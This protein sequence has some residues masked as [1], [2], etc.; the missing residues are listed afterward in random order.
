MFKFIL[1]RILYGLLTLFLITTATF[2]LIAGAPGDPIA[3]KV[4]QMPEK[5]QAVI[6]TKYGL[7]KPVAVRY[8]IYMKNLITKGDFGESIVYT[9]KS[10]N[11][12]IKTNAPISAKIGIIALAL[13][14]VIGVLLGLISA[15]HRGKTPDYI[16][17]VLVVLAI[18]VPSFVFAALLQYFIGFKWKLAPVFGWG[19]MKHYILPVLAYTIGGVASYTKFMRSS[20][21]SVINEDYI[22]TAKSKGCKKGRVVRKHVMRNSM[23]PIVTMTGP[24]IAGI[25]AGSFVIERI[26]SIPGLGSYYVKSVTNNDYTMILGFTIFFAALYVLS[27][28]F[29]DIMYGIVDPRIRITSSED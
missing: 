29:V 15:L 3:A 4:G 21:L 24:A 25:F 19:E 26:F 17:R 10:V 18:C 7:D 20:T 23:I 22:L 13:Q 9:G 2:F 27:L 11:D 5:A 1:K 12:I 6:R 14:I 8:G 28:I 16:I